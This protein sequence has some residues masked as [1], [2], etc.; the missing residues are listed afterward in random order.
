M[1]DFYRL[2]KPSVT[3]FCQKN[4]VFPRVLK[5]ILFELKKADIV[6]NLFPMFVRNFFFLVLHRSRS[7]KSALFLFVAYKQ[8]YNNR[9][10]CF[11]KK[12]NKEIC[13]S[14]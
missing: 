13:K 10:M 11:N 4:T 8:K 12:V 6:Q 5:E 7:H 3:A 14:I 9:R 1:F 2:T